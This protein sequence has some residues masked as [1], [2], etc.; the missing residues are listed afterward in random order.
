MRSAQLKD[1]RAFD[2]ERQGRWS[3]SSRQATLRR[4]DTAMT[5][6]FRRVRSG[7]K[8]GYP[9]FRGV[10]YFDTVQFPKDGDG[11]RWDSTPHE[12]LTRVRLRGVGHVRVHG[13]RAV[14]GKVKTVSVKREG[15]RWY[16][17]LTAERDQPELLPA[18]GSGAGIDLGIANF[19][20]TFVAN[21]RHARKAAARL[22][23]PEE[24]RGEGREPAPHGP[25]S[26]P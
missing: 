10:G 11:C 2:P 19:H 21:P 15:N 3:F 26:T 25:P 20:G 5:A 7:E 4:L 24:G 18:T 1:I 22:K 12:R 16:V 23:A 9:R 6:F 17:V 14:A 13:H 8:P